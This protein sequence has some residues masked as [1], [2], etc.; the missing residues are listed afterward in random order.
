METKTSLVCPVCGRC[1]KFD[2]KKCGCCGTRK[3][4]KKFVYTG[5]EKLRTEYFSRGLGGYPAK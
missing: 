4:G 3:Q 2:G 5:S 1:G